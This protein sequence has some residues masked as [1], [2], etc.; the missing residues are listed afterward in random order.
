MTPTTSSFVFLQKS[1]KIKFISLSDLDD[2]DHVITNKSAEDIL[3]NSKEWI[4]WK[5]ISV[6]FAFVPWIFLFFRLLKLILILLSSTFLF[7]F[8]SF[9]LSEVPHNRTNYDSWLDL[10]KWVEFMENIFVD[11]LRPLELRSAPSSNHPPQNSQSS[12]KTQITKIHIFSEVINILKLSAGQHHW[13][14]GKFKFVL[15]LKPFLRQIEPISGTKIES[16]TRE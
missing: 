16:W 9:R 10:L 2:T 4:S 3:F 6:R 8:L 15:H 12:L 5:L 7:H 13:N 1:P 14:G 11:A